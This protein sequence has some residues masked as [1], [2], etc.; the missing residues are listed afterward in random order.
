MVVEIVTGWWYNSIALLA[1]GF[2]RSSHALA[3]GLRAVAFAAARR[4][5]T[6]RRFS[7]GTWKIELLGGFASAVPIIGLYKT[8]VIHHRGPWRNID[9]VEYATLEWVD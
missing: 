9:A 7:F 1:D 2:H 3:I 6:R 4:Y 8:E 5:A